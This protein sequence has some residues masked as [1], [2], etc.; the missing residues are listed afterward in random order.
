MVHEDLDLFLVEL[1]H[2]CKRYNYSLGP[3]FSVWLVQ[4]DH[5]L[6]GWS[7]NPDGTWNP[8]VGPIK[9]NEDENENNELED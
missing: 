6:I 4:H 1:F 5:K 3:N 2:L 9:E 7:P 8:M